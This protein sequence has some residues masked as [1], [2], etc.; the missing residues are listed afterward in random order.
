MN[1]SEINS[2]D[3]QVV[4]TEVKSNCFYQI[5][6]N[7]ITW[8]YSPPKSATTFTTDTNSHDWTA[9]GLYSQ[10][11]VNTF[12]TTTS[13]GGVSDTAISKIGDA[14]NVH[15]MYV[16]SIDKQAFR[17]SI[18]KNTKLTIPITG[19]TGSLSGLT[20]LNLY[21]TFFQ[22]NDS[23]SPCGI[24]PCSTYKVDSLQS[25]SLQKATELAGIGYAYDPNNNP[26][27]S[28]GG[29]YRSGL[30]YL[31]SDNIEWSGAT[32]TGTTWSNGWSGNSR[33][34]FDSGKLAIFD[35]NQHNE[36]VGVI[37][38]DS[39]LIYL[40]HP[41]IVDN[42]NTSLITGGT[43]ATG[44]TF[45]TTDLNMV[46]R[47]TDLS[48]ELQININLLPGLYTESSNQSRL[49]AKQNGIDCDGLV[50]LTE[51]CLYDSSERLMAI[52]NLTVPLTKA[53]SNFALLKASITMDGG[54]KT[55][56]CD[57]GRITYPLPN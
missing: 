53:D 23:T 40:Y 31:F 48:T 9:F 33:Y 47:D 11:N 26:S 43:V 44:A 10:L 14:Y 51:V 24:G 4:T 3:L 49:D 29:E 15:G 13:N 6:G 1:L 25:E 34:T 37:N 45:N 41:D 2:N 8:T 35:G 22:Q 55:S 21:T 57:D 36:S 30:L 28:T 52:G 20:S 16:G 42:F 39:G 56:P 12:T 5:G 46:A 38:L 17:A 50:K 54:V 7:E 18:Y 19:G 27:E 32:N